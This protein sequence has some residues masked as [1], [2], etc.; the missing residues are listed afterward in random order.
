MGVSMKAKEHRMMAK[1][2]RFRMMGADGAFLGWLTRASLESAQ[3]DA[4]KCFRT[5]QKVTVEFR[6]EDQ[7]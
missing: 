1:E 5:G 3:R 2:W 6:E 4:E 7:D